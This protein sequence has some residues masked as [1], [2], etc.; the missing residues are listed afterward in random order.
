[1]GWA[2]GLDTASYSV[3]YIAGW[4]GGD[5]AV[6][7]EAATQAVTV[8]LAIDQDLLIKMQPPAT[9]LTRPAEL[10]PPSL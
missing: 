3:P 8:A 4:S 6:L 10:P 7:R 1:M 9:I 5:A 2:T